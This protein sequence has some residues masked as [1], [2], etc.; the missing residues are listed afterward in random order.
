[1][2]TN[3]DMKNERLLRIT[4]LI[5]YVLKRWRLLLICMII[6]G[7]LLNGFSCLRSYQSMTALKN[8]DE[9]KEDLLQYEANLSEKEILEVR[10]SV[11]SYR[12]YKQSYTDYLDYNTNSIKMQLDANAVSTQKMIYQITSNQID[13][14]NISEVFAEVIPND[15]TCQ[16]ILEKVDWNVDIPY[17]KELITVTNM[18]AGFTSDSGQ[19]TTN[20]VENSLTDNMSILVTVNIIAENKDDCAVIRDAI[21]EEVNSLINNLQDQFGKFDV[22]K[23]SD[24]YGVKADDDLRQDQQNLVTSINNVNNSMQTLENNLTEDQKSYFS[25]LI[26]EDVKLE[27][28]GNESSSDIDSLQIQYIN[29]KYIIVG[30]VLGAILSCLY[31]MCKFCVNRYL[32]SPNYVLD[33]L[34]SE[35]LVVC[36]ENKKIGKKNNIIDRRIEKAF[37]NDSALYIESG[38][39]DMLYARIQIAIEKNH[40]RKIHLTSSLMSGEINQ[41]ILKL[42]EYLEKNNIEFSTGESIIL[43]KDSLEKFSVADGVVFV[44]QIN[45]SLLSEIDNEVSLCSKYDVQ[46]LGFVLV[47]E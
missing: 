28:S 10:N 22:K 29:I 30:A 1:M 25:A 14:I 23:I 41:F 17:V 45:K 13:A 36:T 9:T 43:N 38:Q 32:L 34:N 18:N 16:K 7:I 24:L 46:N 12:I 21:E 6:F 11:D 31:I 4:D 8:Q 5:E 33:N 37:K 42:S 27:E 26:D 15:D 20:I 47:N 40:L 35:A 19:V 39:L 2:V 44:E 3:L